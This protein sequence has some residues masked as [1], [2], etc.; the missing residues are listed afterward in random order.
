M[1]KKDGGLSESP[2]PGGHL[3]EERERLDVLL[4]LV[5]KVLVAGASTHRDVRRTGRVAEPEREQ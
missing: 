1:K 5:L 2:P 3:H 4:Q